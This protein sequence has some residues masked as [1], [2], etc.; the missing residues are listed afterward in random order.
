MEFDTF[1]FV[2]YSAPIVR[3]IQLYKITQIEWVVT[4]VLVHQS[5]LTWVKPWT[6]FINIIVISGYKKDRMLV[7]FDWRIFDTGLFLS[8]P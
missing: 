1:L 7:S 2:L 5:H 8:N 3:N 4:P 6:Y